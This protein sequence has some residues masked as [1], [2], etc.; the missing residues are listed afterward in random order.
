MRGGNKQC[1][2][3]KDLIICDYLIKQVLGGAAKVLVDHVLE[4]DLGT[5]ANQFDVA[6][7]HHLVLE[8][9][10]LEDPVR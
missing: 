3:L 2:F 9:G 1:F 10:E 7:P 5:V 6:L 4:F 8:F